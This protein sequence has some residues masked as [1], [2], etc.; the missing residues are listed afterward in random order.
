MPDVP[1]CLITCTMSIE[2][3]FARKSS[4]VNVKYNEHN[5]LHCPIS[6]ME[7]FPYSFLV[8][9]KFSDGYNV[10]SS[11]VNEYSLFFEPCSVISREISSFFPMYPKASRKGL[12]RRLL[13]I[14]SVLSIRES[15]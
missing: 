6:V 13:C 15:V 11:L 1:S 12:P 10:C 14:S 8:Y 5:A 4:P 3:G 9:L 7:C 2:R